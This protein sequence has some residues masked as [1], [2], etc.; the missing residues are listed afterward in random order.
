[1]PATKRAKVINE[2]PN[3]THAFQDVT[4][5]FAVDQLLRQF[6]FTIH[7]RL[8]TESPVW[9]KNRTYWSQDAAQKTL[10]KEALRLAK[11][12]QGGYYRGVQ[13]D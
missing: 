7:Q 8:K 2:A 6:G 1:M 12:R 5:R 9:Y 4:N 11:M 10:P 13:H 3:R